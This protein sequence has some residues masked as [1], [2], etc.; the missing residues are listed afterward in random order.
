MKSLSLSSRKIE[1]LVY[2]LV[3]MLVFAVPYFDRGRADGVDWNRLAKEWSHLSGFLIV[4][5]VNVYLFIPRFLFEKQYLWYFAGILIMTM[6]IVG[7]MQPRGAALSD[8][9]NPSPG[10]SPG[11]SEM[12][13]N[14]PPHMILVD[15]FIIAILVVG[16]GT[17]SKL[18]SKWLDEEKLRKDVEKEQL[19]TNLALLRHQVSPHFFMN[20]LNNIHALID[21]NTEQAKDAIVRLSTLM[22]YL[23]YDSAQGMISSKKE[24]EF[25]KSFISLMKLR[26]P[27]TVDIVVIVPER[28]PD[29]QIPP[30]LLISLLENA[31]KHGISYQEK[32]FVNC[33]LAVRESRLVCTVKNSKHNP[34]PSQ[35]V[36]QGEYSGIGLQNIKKSLELL[37]G[38]SYPLTIKETDTEFE[39]QLAIPL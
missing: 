15:N 8:S 2:A 21:I 5:V 6:L 19:K 18:V 1:S 12:P 14:K 29:V 32:S 27:D 25:I 33:E 23:L 17:A 26:Y 39:V 30:M 28:I 35:P 22:R 11:K 9:W 20:T 13:E 7:A 3:W 34:L 37:Y 10:S 4:F 31:F 16:S 38:A 36:T 24:I